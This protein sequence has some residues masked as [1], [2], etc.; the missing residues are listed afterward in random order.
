MT[1]IANSGSINLKKKPAQSGQGEYCLKNSEKS[2]WLFS[3]TLAILCNSTVIE[4]NGDKIQVS[5]GFKDSQT[6]KYIAAVKQPCRWGYWYEHVKR[7]ADWP[8]VPRQPFF[9]QPNNL[10]NYSL[11]GHWIHCSPTWNFCRVIL[12]FWLWLLGCTCI[13]FNRTVHL[14]LGRRRRVK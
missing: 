7:K 5:H 13:F 3:G 11:F 8:R 4:M 12:C 1:V 10:Q 2:P 6:L 9:R 14:N